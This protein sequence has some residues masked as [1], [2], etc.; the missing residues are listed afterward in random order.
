MGEA[1]GNGESE[2]DQYANWYSPHQAAA[3]LEV[4]VRRIYALAEQGELVAKLDANG[5][6]R[7]DP[8]QVDALAPQAGVGIEAQ[9]NQTDVIRAL[10]NVLKVQ[11]DGQQAYLKL[12]PEATVKLLAQQAEIIVRQQSII[13]DLHEEN[14]QLRKE[15]TEMIAAHE[16]V[17]T[18]QHERDMRREKM[19]REQ[20]RYDKA[21]EELG[22]L[23]PR[24]AEQVV[25]GGDVQKLLGSLDPALLF[26]LTSEASPLTDEQK[27]WVRSIRERIEAKAK[28]LP[29]KASSKASE[30]VSEPVE[31]K[32]DAPGTEPEAPKSSEAAP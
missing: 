18:E 10:Q 12:V 14:R 19:L 24:L 2:H 16:K 3:V 30:P 31:R 22:E 6:K 11:Q 26:A 25:I 7:F 21:W 20:A 32:P 9:R 28:K 4:G 1:G 13:G 29:A 17:L 23:V 8:E 27:V 15:R 5:R